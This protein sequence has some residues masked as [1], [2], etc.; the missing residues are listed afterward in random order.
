MSIENKASRPPAADS[1]ADKQA[2]E[3]ERAARFDEDEFHAKLLEFVP[4]TQQAAADIKQLHR[5]FGDELF[6]NVDAVTQAPDAPGMTLKRKIATFGEFPNHSAAEKTAITSR[7]VERTA[8]LLDIFTTLQLKIDTT[9]EQIGP[10][11]KERYQPLTD[12]SDEIT[13]VLREK[14]HD[15]N[16]NY[17][18]IE[19]ALYF[20]STLSIHFES[21][22]S[23]SN[24][25]KA[26]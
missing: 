10:S 20:S 17:Q 26:G 18:K 16:D 5:D 24:I 4:R 2:P 23:Q 11:Q 8:D 12:Y 6:G 22:L 13:Q 15:V 25:S 19:N 21:A 1:A 3:T 7:A 9:I 14:W